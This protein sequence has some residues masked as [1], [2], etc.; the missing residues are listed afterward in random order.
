MNDKITYSYS[1]RALYNVCWGP[2]EHVTRFVRARFMAGWSTSKTVSN[3]TLHLTFSIVEK[4]RNREA[5]KQF[6][7][8][9]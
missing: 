4:V 9:L 2:R 5:H 1:V 8:D 6:N 3:E 7:Y